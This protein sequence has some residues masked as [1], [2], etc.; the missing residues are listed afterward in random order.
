MILL[1]GLRALVE[2]SSAAGVEFGETVDD[3]ARGFP[4]CVHI[5]AGDFG[6]SEDVHFL[7]Y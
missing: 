1:F 3:D 6:S 5:N 2:Q 7:F 4:A